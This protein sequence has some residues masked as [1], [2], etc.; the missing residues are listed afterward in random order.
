[1]SLRIGPPPIKASAMTDASRLGQAWRRMLGGQRSVQSTAFANA[2][3]EES[4]LH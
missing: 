4:R 2:L 1:M 3:K